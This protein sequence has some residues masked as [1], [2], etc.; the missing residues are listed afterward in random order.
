MKTVKYN[1]NLDKLEVTYKASEQVR[2]TLA[3]IKTSE[4][5]N[6]IRVVRVENP[7]YYQHEFLLYG[8][9]FNEEW[10][11]YERPLGYLKFGSYNKNRQHI[12]ILF[13]NA[14]LYDFYLLASRFY[15]EDALSLEFYRVSKLDI[16]L[17]LNINIH[18]RLYKL[19]RDAAYSLIILN[20][21]YHE[22]DKEVKEVLHVETGTRKRPK[23]NKSFYIQNKDKSLSLRCYNKS[24]EIVETEKSYISNIS[25]KLPMYRLEVSFANHKNIRKSLNID[26]E[27]VYCKLQDDDFLLSLFNTTL[28]RIIRVGKGRKRYNL[29]KVLVPQC[30]N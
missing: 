3:A 30:F 15:I 21:Q 24:A 8:K 9:D 26:E 28:D 19:F 17:D 13:D 23:K 18:R 5:I 22:M 6:E 27:E 7:K 29:L 10:G 16:A 4:V 2:N 25:G 11:V 12:Y 1:I 20:R 14:L